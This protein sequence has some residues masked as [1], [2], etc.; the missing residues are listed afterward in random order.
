[1]LR[2]IKIS[3]IVS[4]PIQHFCPQYAS[5]SLNSEIQV[6]VY[7]ASSLGFKQYHDENFGQTIS[8]K[9]LYL[10]YFDHEFL[11]EGRVIPISK[12]I[13]APELEIKL[14]E[15]NPDLVIV[16]GY[17][18]K[19]Q[20][21]A[22]K[23]AKKNQIAIVYIS[24]AQRKGDKS[25]IREVVKYPFLYRYFSKIS[26]FLTVGNANEEFYKFYGV[27]ERR[28][29]RM[30]FPID[31]VLYKKSYESKLNLRNTLRVNLGIMESELV[32]SVVGKLIESKNQGDIIES[33]IQLEK[34]DIYCHLLVLGSG[35]MMEKWKSKAE[36]L[37]TSK[38]H[39]MGFVQ[40]ED[41]PSYY[42]SSDIYVHPARIEAH[43]LAVSEAIYMGCPV[44][45]SDKCGSY[46]ESDDVQ[47]NKN[48]FVYECC[49]INQLS[50]SI[51]LLSKNH[52]LRKE[53]SAYSHKIAD[54]FQK[55]SHF[56]ILDSLKSLVS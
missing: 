4:H 56:D 15:F 13:D 50:E 45:I 51:K 35:V 48:G 2:K 33:M 29:F 28:L 30:H 27:D 47:I 1:M 8:W 40:P 21:R 25:I 38:V 14:K 41:L 49:N 39:F 46:G 19:I 55:Q 16:Y 17:F 43:S 9:N 20:R 11:N 18:Q 6:K 5:F 10:E 36:K 12:N 26:A 44:I 54:Q 37:K 23:W 32:L 7:F 24:D 31:I 22:F 34:E 53:F 3:I 52:S 42:A